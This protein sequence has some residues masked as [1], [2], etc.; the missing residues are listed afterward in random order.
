MSAPNSSERRALLTLA[1]Q[2]GARVGR[3]R[4]GHLRLRLPSGAIVVTGGTVSDHRGWR[5]AM[6]TLRRFGR[7]PVPPVE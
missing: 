5:N 4:K 3:T 1:D 7:Q 2:L 6:A